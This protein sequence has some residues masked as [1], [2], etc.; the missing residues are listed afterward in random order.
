MILTRPPREKVLRTT[1][2]VIT[3]HS[4]VEPLLVQSHGR[5]FIDSVF[6]P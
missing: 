1:I 3:A 4:A 5:L 2:C 6:F